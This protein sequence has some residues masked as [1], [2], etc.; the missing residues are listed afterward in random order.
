L[1]QFIASPSLGWFRVDQCDANGALARRD[2]APVVPVR[3]V[4]YIRRLSWKH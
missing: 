4:L 1:E 3:A 2:V